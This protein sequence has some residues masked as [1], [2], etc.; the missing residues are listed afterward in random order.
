M[1]R[2][3]TAGAFALLVAGLGAAMPAQA[4][5]GGSLK[6]Y[7]AHLAKTLKLRPTETKRVEG[8]SPSD[9]YHNYGGKTASGLPLQ[10][11]VQVAGDKVYSQALTVTTK[12]G[13]QT[14]VDTVVSLAE[15][16]WQEATEGHGKEASKYIAR[17]ISSGAETGVSRYRD[18]AL[19]LT[20]VG[21]GTQLIWVIG[22]ELQPQ[23]KRGTKP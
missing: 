15:A 19:S 8:G 5:P 7:Q 6:A 22:A 12:A 11:S 18:V 9:W 4:R 17:Q 13:R 2:W 1:N 23:T 16:F 14:D 20:K 21:A 3:V 10:L